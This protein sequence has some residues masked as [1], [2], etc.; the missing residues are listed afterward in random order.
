MGGGGAVTQYAMGQ[1]GVCLGGMS[2]QGYPPTH[3]RTDTPRDG[4]WNGRSASYWNSAFLFVVQTLYRRWRLWLMWRFIEP[5]ALVWRH[6]SAPS[7]TR[8][9]VVEENLHFEPFL[10]LV[11]T[12]HKVKIPL[13]TPTMPLASLQDPWQRVEIHQDRDVSS[14]ALD[15]FFLL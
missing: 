5:E 9:V 14:K 15:F 4:N 2:V 7:W 8:K 10:C 12:S 1:E 6:L 3:P 11:G 13:H